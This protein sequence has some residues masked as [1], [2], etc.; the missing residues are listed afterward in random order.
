M[1]EVKLASLRF[2][3][4]ARIICSLEVLLTTT[5]VLSPEKL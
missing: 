1:P 3:F 5:V 4:F 2:F